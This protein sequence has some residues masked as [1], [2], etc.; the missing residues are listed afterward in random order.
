MAI[1]TEI[2]KLRKEWKRHRTASL[3]RP[4]SQTTRRIELFTNVPRETLK[5]RNAVH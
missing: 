5:V 3:L 2:H 4:E 1:T